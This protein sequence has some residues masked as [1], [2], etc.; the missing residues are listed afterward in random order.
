MSETAG[1]K[2]KKWPIV[3]GVIVIVVAACAIGF[4]VWHAQ[5]SFC[6]AI[7]H[8]P[9]DKY[10]ES[11]YE[12]D[13]MCRVHAEA[14]VTC[15]DCHVPTLSEQVQEGITWIKGDFRPNLDLIRY[16]SDQCMV[17][18]DE[19]AVR[20]CTAQMEEAGTLTRDPHANVHQ[21]T[22][23]V[24]CHRSHRNQVD[25][26]TTCH[27]NGGQVMITYPAKREYTVDTTPDW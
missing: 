6:N 17:C 16:D 18:H 2:R 26:C 9:M 24:D 19:D 21:M 8:S 13:D 12:G 10:V 14:D 20:A 11:Y 27:D 22:D 5:P 15:L 7:C 3:L 25:Y 1:K 4:S 23:C